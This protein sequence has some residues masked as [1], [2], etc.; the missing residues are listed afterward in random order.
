M[1]EALVSPLLLPISLETRLDPFPS[2]A[3]LFVFAHDSKVN[4]MWQVYYHPMIVYVDLA[5]VDQT[6]PRKWIAR[7]GPR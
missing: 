4:N 1:Q 6:D 5:V 3:L 2:R 7:D